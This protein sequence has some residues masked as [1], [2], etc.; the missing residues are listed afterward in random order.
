VRNFAEQQAEFLKTMRIASV[1][2]QKTWA[3]SRAIILKAI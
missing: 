1:E 3:N 2:T